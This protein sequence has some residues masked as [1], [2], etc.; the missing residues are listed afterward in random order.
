MAER[1]WRNLE[2]V[3]VVTKAQTLD[4]HSAISRHGLGLV[5][6]HAV[7]QKAGVQPLNPLHLFPPP[8]PVLVVGVILHVL[9]PQ[10]LGLLHKR[11]LFGDRKGFP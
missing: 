9:N 1:L 3:V 6:G 10:P 8:G 2:T 5:I 4:A 11:L 7:D